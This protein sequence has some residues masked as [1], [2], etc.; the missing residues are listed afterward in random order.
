MMKGGRNYDLAEVELPKVVGDYEQT[1]F[2]YADYPHTPGY[3]V[4]L[5]SE[6]WIKDRDRH[7][8]KS[9]MCEPR[10]Q[11]MGRASGLGGLCERGLTHEFKNALD[12][13]WNG[14]Y[15][16]G[17]MSARDVIQSIKELPAIEQL[18]VKQFL[19]IRSNRASP[20]IRAKTWAKGLCL[21]SCLVMCSNGRRL[22]SSLTTARFWKSSRNSRHGADIP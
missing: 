17:V 16:G 22:M 12:S 21:R 8:P 6:K 5:T 14:V 4:S 1:G 7:H 9:Q 3:G 15:C 18:E 19:I 2:G 11:R 10:S 13:V 20:R